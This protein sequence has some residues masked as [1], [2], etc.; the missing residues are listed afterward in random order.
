LCGDPALEVW[1]LEWLPWAIVHGHS[2][3]FTNALFAGSGGVNALANGSAMFPALVLSP[4]TVLFGPIAAFNVAGTLAPVVSGWCMFLFARK[5]TRFVPGQ[6]LAGLLWGFSPFM[7][8]NLG[9][10]HI[11][12]ALGFFPPLAALVLYDLLVQHRRRP[13]VNGAWFGVLVILQVFT[14]AE[15]LV[16]TGLV[17][18]VGL[19][20]AICLA[21][22]FVWDQRGA[23]STA[24]GTAVLIAATVLAY[25]AWFAVAG[26]RHV[27]GKPWPDSSFLSSPVTAIV[28]A[29]TNIHK[30]SAV[31]AVAGYLGA[32]GPSYGYLGWG[33]LVFVVISA[34]LWWRRRLAW[35]AVVSG[36]WAL[37]LSNGRGGTDWWPWNVF[38]RIPLLSDAWPARF[39]DLVDLSAAILLAIAIDGWWKQ[40]KGTTITH[41]DA[42]SKS[43]PFRWNSTSLRVMAGLV[44]VAGAVA[45]LAP[46]AASYTLPFT[47][48]SSSIPAWFTH[49]ARRLPQGTRVLAIP[50]ST[51]PAI[52]SNVMVY[53]AEDSLRFDLAGGYALVPGAKGS[54]S[55]W[56]YPLGGTTEILEDLSLGP[57]LGV[58]E[59]TD[60]PDAIVEVRASLQRWGIQVFVIAQQNNAP[61]TVSYMTAVYGRAPLWQHGAWVWYGEVKRTKT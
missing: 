38:N 32:R 8:D 10:G 52:D 43:V 7:F 13:W 33:L 44:V 9:Y 28:N 16:M 11:H 58:P 47:E 20:M 60:N 55:I 26:P 30:P 51:L 19:A 46:I 36:S 31:D 50:F 41:G 59:P 48:Q 27:S 15:L 21:P 37:I 3:F 49:D 23:I 4:I 24:G 45:A 61:Y 40:I 39:S 12:L 14:G 2:P 53:Q 5:I 34:P 17:G 29:G 6:V 35:C 25:P 57:Y 18:V 54:T 42:L 1:W 56:R 22:R